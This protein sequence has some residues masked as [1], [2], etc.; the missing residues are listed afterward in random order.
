MRGLLGLVT[1]SAKVKWVHNGMRHTYASNHLTH[2]QD[3]GK[4]MLQL[5]HVG[6]AGILFNHY[7][8]LVK[9]ADADAYWKIMPP[10]QQ[11]GTVLSSD[12]P[13]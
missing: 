11:E 6:G 1:R 2:F 4:T 3:I 10:V 12:E 9:P 8:N 13:T 5:G 7:R